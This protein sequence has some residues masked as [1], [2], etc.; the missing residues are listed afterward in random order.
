MSV[1]SWIGDL[2]SVF[3]FNGR[4]GEVVP[5]AGD[6]SAAQ[7]TFDGTA[8]SLA[9]LTAQAAIDEVAQGIGRKQVY[10]ELAV[11]GLTGTINALSTPDQY[12]SISL[13]STGGSTTLIN[14]IV[15]PTSDVNGLC[16]IVRLVYSATFSTTLV[17]NSGSAAAGNKIITLDGANIT[18]N[19]SPSSSDVYVLLTRHNGNWFATRLG[20]RA[21]SF[22]ANVVT[23]PTSVPNANDLVYAVSATALG[24]ITPGSIMP[25]M[26]A[27]NSS[28]TALTFS[29]NQRLTWNG[30]ATPTFTFS[31][32][33]AVDG[34][35][36]TIFFAALS[37]S[38]ITL[39]SDLDPTGTVV[40]AFD[41]TSAAYRLTMQYLADGPS[42]V[43]SLRKVTDL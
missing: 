43:C 29:A 18:S 9:A 14:G 4:S 12:A 27:S 2:F 37:L 32:G 1:K 25:R 10:N 36:I 7:V 8:S 24:I 31:S 40:Y 21:V 3:S 42:I 15:A 17:H 23:L 11:T 22:G 35:T 6:Y 34:A 13:T 16:K 5:A 30:S 20:A 26:T 39:S 28:T 38:S 41:S 33:A 19:Q